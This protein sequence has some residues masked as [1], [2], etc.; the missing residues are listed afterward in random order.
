MDTGS[1]KEKYGRM[2]SLALAAAIIVL[3]VYG[4]GFIAL[5][6]SFIRNKIWQ[7]V[8]Y[9]F[10]GIA[11]VTGLWLG[12]T[13]LDGNGIYIAFIPLVLGIVAIWNTTRRNQ[14]TKLPPPP[15]H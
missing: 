6:L 7:I 8:T 3:S 10:G 14:V 4:S 1:E 12:Y 9:V 15:P 2:E 11:I 5:G 13:L